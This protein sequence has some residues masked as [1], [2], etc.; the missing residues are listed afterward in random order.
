MR[1]RGLADVIWWHSLPDCI[2]FHWTDTGVSLVA[3]LDDFACLQW[4]PFVAHLFALQINR[5]YAV[6]AKNIA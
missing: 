1:W 2:V 3:F 5:L 4:S 6:T